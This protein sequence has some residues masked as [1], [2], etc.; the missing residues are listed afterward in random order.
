MSAEGRTVQVLFFFSSFLDST[1]P[2]INCHFPSSSHAFTCSKI[3]SPVSIFFFPL[4]KNVACEE[5]LGSPIREWTFGPTFRRSLA[6]KLN[7]CHLLGGFDFSGDLFLSLSAEGSA[8]QDR[9]ILQ[10]FRRA[11]SKV[12]FSTRYFGTVGGGVRL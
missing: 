12:G 5:L 11:T 9:C 10:R 6:L 2:S 7:S 8:K 4:P 1:S 3:C